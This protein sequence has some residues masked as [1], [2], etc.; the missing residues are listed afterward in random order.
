[1]HTL[2]LE[3][4]DLSRA[5]F[6]IGAHLLGDINLVV[7][8]WVLELNP[9]VTLLPQAPLPLLETM[10]WMGHNIHLIANKS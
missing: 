4:H 8:P 5:C 7:P 10:V 9:L 6:P 1:M 3:V 2:V